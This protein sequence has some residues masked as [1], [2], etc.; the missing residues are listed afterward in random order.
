MRSVQSIRIGDLDIGMFRT[1]PACR[2][3]NAVSSGVTKPQH[4]ST[5][6]KQTRQATEETLFFRRDVFAA[7][8][9][10]RNDL[11]RRTAV[12]I[13]SVHG[14]VGRHLGTRSTFPATT[15]T[16]ATATTLTLA[17]RIALSRH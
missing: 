1:A 6:G 11:S 14:V 2:E 5:T 3:I 13:I 12:A 16:T 4:A 9:R 8:R 7:R 10:L 15:A 17:R